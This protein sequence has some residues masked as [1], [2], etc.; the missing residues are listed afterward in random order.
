[1]LIWEATGE[2]I[3]YK[4]E[5]YNKVIGTHIDNVIKQYEP[6]KPEDY[7]ST[8]QVINYFKSLDDMIDKNRKSVKESYIQNQID[9]VQELLYSTLYKLRFLQ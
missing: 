1:M 7:K 4:T 9:T 2:E 3:L 8:E 5:H 6:F